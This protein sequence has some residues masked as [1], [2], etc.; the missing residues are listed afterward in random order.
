MSTEM[1]DMVKVR[2][3]GKVSAD[4]ADILGNFAKLNEIALAGSKRARMDA[5]DS[6]Q[7][8]T[9][10]KNGVIYS[11]DK[12]GKKVRISTERK[13]KAPKFRPLKAVSP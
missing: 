3:K 5:F 8:I 2:K 1:V 11:V 13:R 9:V 12:T 10:M 4:R 7:S 6:I